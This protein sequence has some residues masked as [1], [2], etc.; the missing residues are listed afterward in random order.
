[1]IID[2]VFTECVYVNVVERVVFG[3]TRL[4]ESDLPR[5]CRVFIRGTLKKARGKQQ[6]NPGQQCTKE[7][8]QGKGKR[9]VL[10]EKTCLSCL[11]V[12]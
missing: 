12:K 9:K 5:G 6:K 2:V 4:S 7:M 11:S 1:M 10:R 8:E 3:W